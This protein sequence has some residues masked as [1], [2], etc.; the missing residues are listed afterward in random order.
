M[1]AKIITVFNQKGGCAKT[2]TTMQLAGTFALR[3][4]KVFVVD[5]DAQ[6]TSTLWSLGAEDASPFPATVLSFAPLQEGFLQKLPPLMEKYDVVLI[7]CPPSLGSRVPW[8]ALSIADLALI[9]VIPVMDNVWASKQAEDLIL[10]ARESRNQNGVAVELKAAYLLSVVRRGKIYA[11]C[12]DELKRNSRIPILK[13]FISH[14]N[15][16]PESQLFGCCVKSMGASA[17]TTEVD[18]AAEEIAGLVGLKLTKQKVS[19]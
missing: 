8:A 3:G 17:A 1:S 7:D 14:R 16:F 13:A 15:A 11:A 9:P 4:L 5:M 6:N 19:K 18:A 12:L 2:M 10:Q